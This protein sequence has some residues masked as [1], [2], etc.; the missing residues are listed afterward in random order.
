[1][2][3]LCYINFDFPLQ[4]LNTLLIV[5]LNSWEG[6]CEFVHG[7]VCLQVA[8]IPQTAFIFGATVRDNILFGL[9]YDS[10]RY[11]H[12]L[13]ASSLGPDLEHLPGI[14]CPLQS[15][16]RKVWVAIKDTSSQITA[17]SV[18]H[19][20]DMVVLKSATS[21]ASSFAESSLHLNQS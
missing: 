8:F 16:A 1:M 12:A 4:S 11:Q 15:S 9:P 17:H 7:E 10:S 5:V 3:Q 6:I 14:L 2:H 13:E 19:G 18:H 21:V 20:E